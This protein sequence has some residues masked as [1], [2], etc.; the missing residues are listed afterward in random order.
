MYET[1]VLI[2]VGKAQDVILGYAELGFDVDG[3]RIIPNGE[4]ENDPLIESAS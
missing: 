2:P 3:L 4:F 1:P